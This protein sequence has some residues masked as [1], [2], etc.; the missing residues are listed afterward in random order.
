MKDIPNFD[1]GIRETLLASSVPT[2]ASL[3]WKRGFRNTVLKGPRPITPKAVRFAGPARTVHTL[4]LREDL[5]DAQNRGERPNLHGMA[6]ENIRQGDVLAVAM[7][8]ERDTAFMGDIMTTFLAVKGAA[9]AVLDGGVS[10]AAAIAEIEMPVFAEAN[11]PRPLTSHRI[12]M[13]LDVPVALSGVTV[14]PGDVLMGDANGI[15]AIPA[16]I[17][18]EIATEAAEREALEEFVLKKV[19]GGA[20]LTGTYPPNEATLKEFES[21]RR[22]SA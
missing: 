10:D 5:L 21:S 14:F 15:V 19:R 20:P 8:G 7:G 16:A 6:V 2:V 22:R 3:L 9:A 11:I 4:P 1:D 18:A 12:V 17:A 13:D